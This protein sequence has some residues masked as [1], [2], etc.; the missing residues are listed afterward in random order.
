MYSLPVSSTQSW[1]QPHS[2]LNSQQPEC[3]IATAPSALVA[4][5]LVR[6]GSKS[7]KYLSITTQPGAAQRQRFCS[8]CRYFSQPLEARACYQMGK[9]SKSSSRTAS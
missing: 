8:L 1:K 2:K 9:A 6:D 7:Q 3:G 4:E 5:H